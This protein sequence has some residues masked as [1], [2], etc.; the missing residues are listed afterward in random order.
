M[1]YKSSGQPSTSA[2]LYFEC[3]FSKQLQGS[4]L[5]LKI[6]FFFNTLQ[7]V[8]FSEEKRVMRGLSDFSKFCSLSG[9]GLGIQIQAFWLQ[10]PRL[11]LWKPCP[12][13]SLSHS[14]RCPACVLVPLVANRTD[15]R[16]SVDLPPLT[17]SIVSSCVFQHILF[18]SMFMDKN[19]I[20]A[21]QILSG[22]GIWFW[23]NVL[24]FLHSFSG[25]KFRW[26][27]KVYQC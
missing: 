10:S 5:F 19:K 20:I 7:D 9:D 14:H 27:E 21:N 15:G 16:H 11:P 4:V 23:R 3:I 22:E 6:V 8:C 2:V 1:F 12:Q 18:G 17:Y 25:H 24:F 26:L 13:L